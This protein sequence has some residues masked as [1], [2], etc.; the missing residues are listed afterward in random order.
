MEASVAQ[1]SPNLYCID[2]FT[3]MQREREGGRQ[4]GMKRRQADCVEW[5]QVNLDLRG[6]L[7]NCFIHLFIYFLQFN[8]AKV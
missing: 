2:R 6:E 7:K 4:R 8:I 5:L 3:H 1:C